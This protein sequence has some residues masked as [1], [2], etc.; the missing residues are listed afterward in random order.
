M[1][2]RIP[3]KFFHGFFQRFYQFLQDSSHV[4]SRDSFS[5]FCPT[6]FW[7][8]FSPEFHNLSR[9]SLVFFFGNPFGVFP[10]FLLGM[11]K[12]VQSPSRILSGIPPGYT[13]RFLLVFQGLLRDSF[14]RDTFRAFRW[15]S[16]RIIFLLFSPGTPGNHPEIKPR[17]RGPLQMLA[18]TFVV[19]WYICS[20]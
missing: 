4:F 3:Y 11:N 17:R 13:Q 5:Y 8:F 7:I 16:S 20:Q 10:G 18:S 15:D 12:S 2:T 19:V 9:N 1:Y 14:C 6:C